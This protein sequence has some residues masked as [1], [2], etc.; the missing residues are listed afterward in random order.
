MSFLIL[1]LEENKLQLFHVRDVP[2]KRSILSVEMKKSEPAIKQF[3]VNTRKMCN[4]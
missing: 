1:F 4:N 3:F 2:V